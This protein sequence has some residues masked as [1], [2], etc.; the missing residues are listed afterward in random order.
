[1][2]KETGY[3]WIC[4]TVDK[5]SNSNEDIDKESLQA[6]LIMEL[7]NE[8]AALE[9]RLVVLIHHLLKWQFQPRKRSKSWERTIREQRK[10]IKRL[11]KNSKNLTKKVPQLALDGYKDAVDEA[12]FETGLS[13]ALFPSKLEYSTEEILDDDFYPEADSKE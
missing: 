6:F 4:E 9:S 7:A 8:D 1:M 13:K 10:S 12:S 2:T 5:L 11:I 3:D